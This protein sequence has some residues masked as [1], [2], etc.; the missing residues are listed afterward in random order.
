MS[1]GNVRAKDSLIEEIRELE[2]LSDELTDSVNYIHAELN[3]LREQ[4]GIEESR[5]KKHLVARSYRA[6][7]IKP[8]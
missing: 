6:R 4:L 5:I 8:N 2:Q 3:R 7:S 1:S